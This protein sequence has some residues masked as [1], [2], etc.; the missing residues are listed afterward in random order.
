MI[1]VMVS[2]G[3]GDDGNDEDVDLEWVSAHFIA[4]FSRNVSL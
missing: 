3:S 1:M 4:S 2:S